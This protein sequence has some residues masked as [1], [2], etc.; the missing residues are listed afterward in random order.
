MNAIRNAKVGTKLLLSFLAVAV[1]TGIVGVVGLRNMSTMDRL[2]R[3]MYEEELLGTS[4]IKEANIDLINI[5]RETRNLLLASS[6]QDRERFIDQIKRYKKDL[7]KEV[8]AAKP[9]FLTKQGQE[10]IAAFDDL[11]KDYAKVSDE[12]VALV[13]K[14]KLQEK[15]KVVDLTMGALRQKADRLDNLMTELGKIK[16]VNAKGYHETVSRIYHSSFGL[17]LA[18]VAGGVLIGIVLGVVITRG[19]MKQ[20]GG[21]PA[22]AADIARKVSEGDLTVNVE[23]NEKYKG[24]LLYAIKNMVDKLSEILGEVNGA[25]ESLSSASEEVSATAQSLSQGASEQ[26]AS[27]EETSAS[28]EQMT[29]SI[30]QNSDNAKTTDSMAKSASAQATEGGEAVSETVDAMRQIADKISIIEDIAYKTNLLALNAAIEAARA[31]EHGKGFAVVADEVRKLAERSQSSAQEISGLAG[32]SVKIAERAGQLISEIVPGIQKTADLVQEIAAA[33]EEQSSGVGQVATAME[34]LDQV[35][36][37]NASAS[38]ELAATSEEMSSQAQQ[39]QQN[40]RFFKLRVDA[41]TA[42]SPKAGRPEVPKPAE[43]RK[44][45]TGESDTVDETAFEQF[46]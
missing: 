5:S 34:Q 3:K 24:S 12:V 9:R 27:V 6:Q 36:Q 46:G 41:V 10:K 7:H 43:P 39:L 22:Y 16:E 15:R 45:E 4:H 8:A 40:V 30:G 31:G 19:L 44:A 18:L 1:I 14:E 32:D 17:M 38:E 2:A 33:S 11:W 21:E 13:K 42:S 23:V 28:L 25:T 29:A 20:L 26:A 35:S 37:Q